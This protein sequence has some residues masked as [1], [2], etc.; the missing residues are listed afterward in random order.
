M[1]FFFFW[2]QTRGLRAFFSVKY[3]F[4]IKILP[5][6]MRIYVTNDCLGLWIALIKSLG[7][8]VFGQNRQEKSI[9]VVCPRK[10]AY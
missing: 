7:L 5:F 10:V 8:L 6:E 1:G 4:M 3:L 9:N 2:G